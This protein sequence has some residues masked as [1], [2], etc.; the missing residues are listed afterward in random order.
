MNRLSKQRTLILPVAAMAAAVIVILPAVLRV[1]VLEYD[2]AI[3]MDVAR[4]IQRSGLPLRSIGAAGVPFYDHTP[5]YVYLL[6]LFVRHSQGGILAA[7]L[8]TTAFGLGCVWL[9]FEI[10][11]RVSG[12]AAGFAA[13][14]LLAISPFFAIHT[15]FIRM[16]VPMVFALLA[17]LLLLVVSER[18]RRTWVILASGVFCAVAVLF[19][20]V[21]V[22][23]LAWCAAYLLW[24]CRQDRRTVLPRLLALTLPTLLGLV[25]WADWAWKLS[26]AVFSSTMRR[27]GSSMAAVNLLDPRARIGAGQWA[28]QLG[29]DLLGPVLVVGLAVS[30]IAFLRRRK[31][32]SDAFYF[33]LWGYLLSAIGIS[34]V[35]RLKEPRHLIGVLPVAALLIGGAI[36][37]VALIRRVWSERR[38]L[39]QTAFVVVT[40]VFLLAASPLRLPS[41]SAGSLGSWLDA[42]YGWRVLENDRFYNVLRLTGEYLREHSEP[43]EVITVAHQAT[44]TAYYADRSYN[45]L[46]T[47]S[48]EAIERTL[49]RSHYLVWDQPTFLALTPAEAEA[50]QAEIAARFRLEQIIRDGARTVTIYR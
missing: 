44:V 29:F 15:F 14:L 31:S 35:V 43:G 40:T 28:H 4:N 20:E 42:P 16:E 30:L 48:R 13:A 17:G 37:W 2:E 10:G 39:A 36:D 18:G 5:L 6:S 34:F 26:P 33:V 32:R 8:V 49:Q 50:V 47:A 11:R 9:T 19:K 3:F 1:H 46:Y 24:L 21:A 38:P 45:M 41:G 27:W 22:L 25:L 7:R 12:P 23:F